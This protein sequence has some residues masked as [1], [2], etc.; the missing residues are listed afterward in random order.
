MLLCAK[1][2]TPFHMLKSQPPEWTIFR[3]RAFNK[4]IKLKRGHQV[5]PSQYDCCSY[6]KRKSGHIQEQN[7]DHVGR[8]GEKE[9]SLIRPQKELI[10]VT[11]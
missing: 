4:E 6:K 5:D 1:Y 9:S 2:V 10:L 3:E 11:P 7:E 8:K